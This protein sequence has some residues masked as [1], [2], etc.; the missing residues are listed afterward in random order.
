MKKQIFFLIILFSFSV[1]GQVKIEVLQSEYKNQTLVFYTPSDYI[2]SKKDT[3]LIVNTDKNG[4][5]EKE[6]SLKETSEIF[7]DLGIYKAR[8]YA[9]PSRNYQ[10]ILPPKKEK[11]VIDSLNLFFKP[12]SV[13]LGIKNIPPEDLNNLIHSFDDIYDSFLEVNFDSICKYRSEKKVRYFEEKIN[14]YYTAIHNVF[15]HQYKKYKIAAMRFMGPNKDYRVITSRYYNGRKIRYRNSAYMDLF[16]LM[17]SNFLAVY[18]STRDGKKVREDIEKAKSI[19]VLKNTILRNIAISDSS[20]SELVALKGIYDAFWQGSTLLYKAF[21]KKQ[22]LMILDSIKNTSK[23]VE[24]RKI[25]QNIQ[26]EIFQKIVRLENKKVDFSAI[27]I[28]RDTV[29]IQNFIGKYT[30]LVFMRTDVV[31]CMED[32]E[33]LRNMYERHQDDMQIISVFTG[34]TKKDFFRLDSS[35]YTWPLLYLYNKDSVLEE[36]QVVTWPKYILLNP[37]GEIIMM[38]APSPQ[39]NF[40]SYLGNILRKKKQLKFR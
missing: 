8:F 3:I 35:K 14:N 27:N 23:I 37:K 5:F 19:V 13:F 40:E 28:N 32:M 33:L 34:R 2:T 24:H 16:N 21:P 11:T 30:Y 36:Y 26:K 18:E 4:A 10:L 17:Y 31:A 7:V 12:T 20:F 29:H 15:F 22:L 25:A 1:Y 9:E 38:P 39:N 6:I